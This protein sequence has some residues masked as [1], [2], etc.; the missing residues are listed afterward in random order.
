MKVIPHFNIR[1][2]VI[3]ILV[4]PQ[5][6]TGGVNPP[7]NNHNRGHSHRLGGMAT[8]AGRNDDNDDNTDD[9]GKDG[10]CPHH[11]KH[12]NDNRINQTTD[13]ADTQDGAG[14]SGNISGQKRSASDAFAN[15]AQVVFEAG[16]RSIDID[17]RPKKKPT[18]KRTRSQCKPDNNKTQ[19]PPPPSAGS[20]ATAA[21]NSPSTHQRSRC[22][23]LASAGV[24]TTELAASVE[25]DE[26][27]PRAKKLRSGKAYE[28]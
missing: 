27:S 3:P 12:C 8:T 13:K 5:E 21:F 26:L 1:S 28:A 17:Q 16:N 22:V 20:S 15:P 2:E 25:Q 23:L 24:A 10:G 18:T 19:G 11:D 14:G 9:N 7:N 6:N 4:F